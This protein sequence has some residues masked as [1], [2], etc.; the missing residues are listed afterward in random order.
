MIVL[1]PI[2]YVRSPR[3]DLRDD[4]WGDVTARIELTDKFGPDCLEGLESFS[5]VEVIFH[6]HLV[7]RLPGMDPAPEALRQIRIHDQTRARPVRRP[8]RSPRPARACRDPRQGG[9]D[10]QEQPAQGGPSRG[11]PQ[12]AGLPSVQSAP[13]TPR[14]VAPG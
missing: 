6:F 7:E 2:G 3:A 4:G 8:P 9:L 5:H 11:S 14:V 13:R 12:P 1:E 10:G